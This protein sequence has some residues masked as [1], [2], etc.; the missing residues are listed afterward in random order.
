MILCVMLN[1]NIKNVVVL[2]VNCTLNM[3]VIEQENVQ[4]TG[5]SLPTIWPMGKYH[6]IALLY[7]YSEVQRA[8]ALSIYILLLFPSNCEVLVGLHTGLQ[9]GELYNNTGNEYMGT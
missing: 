5:H 6:W 9:G 4:P 2:C 1:K 8:S 7:I 3:R